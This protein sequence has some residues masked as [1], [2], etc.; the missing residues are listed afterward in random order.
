MHKYIISRKLTLLPRCLGLSEYLSDILLSNASALFGEARTIAVAAAA[1]LISAS[2]RVVC[3]RISLP[4]F[5]SF[6][7]VAATL[8]LV[9]RGLLHV[10]AI[11][12]QDIPARVMI[13]LSRSFITGNSNTYT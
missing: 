6:K 8:L 11:V 7:D 13:V 5:F 2:L 1:P 10:N 3:I 4:F 12:E 9:D